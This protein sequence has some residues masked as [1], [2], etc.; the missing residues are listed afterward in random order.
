MS[1]CDILIDTNLALHFPPIDQIDWCA[2]AGRAA[3]AV[4]GAI[5]TIRVLCATNG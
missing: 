4:D 5:P 1:D 3:C 2:F